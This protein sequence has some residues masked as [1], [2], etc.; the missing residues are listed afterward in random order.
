MQCILTFVFI[1]NQLGDNMYNKA[2]F[3]TISPLVLNPMLHLIGWNFVTHHE[4]NGLQQT[5]IETEL[6]RKR[7]DLGSVLV[8]SEAYKKSGASFLPAGLF[9]D[10]MF[11]RDFF[12]IK[13]I[14]SVISPFN[15]VILPRVLLFHQ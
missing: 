10:D 4:R 9:T 15:I 1:L 5:V 12:A 6:A 8:S 11:A 13:K 3:D 2:W 7:V 14:E